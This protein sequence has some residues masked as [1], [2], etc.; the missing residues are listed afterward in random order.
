MR[1][2]RL[3]WMTM[4]FA[5]FLAAP[6]TAAQGTGNGAIVHRLT[7]PAAPAAQPGAQRGSVQFI[8]TATVLRASRF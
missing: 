6:G 4:A 8:G 1:V 5:A 7:I 2:T 3:I